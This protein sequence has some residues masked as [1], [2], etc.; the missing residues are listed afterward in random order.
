MNEFLEKLKGLLEG[1]D[2]VNF[3]EI[4]TELKNLVGDKEGLLNKNKQ[5]LAE[6]KKLQEEKKTLE[7]QVAGFDME[8]FERLKQ[9]E[10]DQAGKKDIDVEALK[11]KLEQQYNVKINAKQKEMDALADKYNKLSKKHEGMIIDDGLQK[12]FARGR[13]VVDQYQQVLK[14]FFKQK[15][16]IETDDE[17]N[18]SIVISDNGADMPIKDYFDY[19][20][21]TEEAKSYLEAEQ[22][23]G[24]GS[25]GSKNFKVTK[26]WSEMTLAE[27][28]ALYQQNPQEYLR[29]KNSKK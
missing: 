13:K 8:E 5:L 26:K 25:T 3:P 19:W 6:K 29:L 2:G 7:E 14:V 16:K 15:A 23:T 1:V 11:A 24:G 20:K 12:E 9:F 4:E 21:N 22:S 17:G 28:T 18:Y 27:K 10:I